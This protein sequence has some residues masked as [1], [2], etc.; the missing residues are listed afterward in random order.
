M[1]QQQASPEEAA[2]SDV[3]AGEMC[4]GSGRLAEASV[5]G[6]CPEGG[7]GITSQCGGRNVA[8]PRQWHQAEAA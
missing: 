8:A 1:C 2:G 7:A 3:D 4:R 6:W 5:R